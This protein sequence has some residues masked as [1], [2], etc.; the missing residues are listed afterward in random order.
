MNFTVFEYSNKRCPAIK[1]A[2]ERLILNQIMIKSYIK[3]PEI[4]GFV[5]VSSD[6]TSFLNR[7]EKCPIS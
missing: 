7:R 2:T 5:I 1:K 6:C 4:E 3:I